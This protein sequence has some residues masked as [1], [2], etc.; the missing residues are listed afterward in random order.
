MTIE[1]VIHKDGTGTVTIIVRGVNVKTMTIGEWSKL[2][3]NP[4]VIE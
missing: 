1:K 2:I 3:A 4:K